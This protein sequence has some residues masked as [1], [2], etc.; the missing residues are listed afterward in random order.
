MVL[1]MML[2]MPAKSDE[3][4]VLNVKPLCNGIISQG[5]TSLEAGERS[6]SMDE[7][8]QAERVDRETMI[9]EWSQF[10]VADKKHC[11]AE[12]TMGGESSYTDLVTWRE[13]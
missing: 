9:K 4:P 3:F 10:S 7:C 2:I 6:V 1:L 13:T 8:L 5:D 11:V 12:A